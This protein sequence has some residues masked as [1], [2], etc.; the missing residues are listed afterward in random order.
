MSAPWPRG[1]V[2]TPVLDLETWDAPDHLTDDDCLTETGADQRRRNV[3]FDLEH[4]ND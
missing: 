2:P 4:D 1:A 3:D